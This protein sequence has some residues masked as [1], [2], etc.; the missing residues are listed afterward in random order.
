MGVELDHKGFVPVD[1]NFRTTCE[2]VY[3]V[4]DVIGCA[5]LAHKAE[6]EGVVCIEQ[7]ATGS[8]DVNYD[9]IPSVVYTNPEIAA[10]GKTEESLQAAGIEFRKGVFPFRANGRARALGQTDG[11]VK[12]L[13]HA[14]TDRLLGV[15]ILG[16]RAGDLIAEAVIA[17]ELGATALDI[18]HCSHAHPTLS[19]ALR[20]A[21]LAVHDR[22]INS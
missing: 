18:A 9:A 22:A 4:G 12:M 20:E 15:H 1:G 14:E 13:A 16:P 7:I 6:Q 8:G 10:V 2:G 21:A 3:A 17:M 5:M 19:D 11:F